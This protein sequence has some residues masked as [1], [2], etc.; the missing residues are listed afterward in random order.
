MATLTNTKIKDT[1]DGLLKTNDNGVLGGTSKE[2]TDGLGNGSGIYIGTNERLGVGT[3]SPSQK[4]SIAGSGGSLSNVASISLWDNNSNSSRRWAIANGA[5]AAGIDQ[6]GAL[7]FSVATGSSTADPITSGSEAMR[8]T[9]A[10]K[11]GIGETNPSQKLDVAGN[12]KL[13]VDGTQNY[14]TFH[15]TTGDINNT[16]YIG[17]RVYAGTERSE[18]ILY[19]GNDGQ[20]DSVGRDRIRLIGANLCFDVYGIAQSYPSDLNGVGTLPTTRAMTIDHTGNVGIGDSTPS[21]K[22]DVNGTIRATGDIIAYSDARVK[23]NVSTIENALDK[24]T[25]LRGVE[26]NKIGDDKQSIGV[27]AQEI[28][29]VLPQVVQED[30]EGMKSVAYG[31][32]VGVLIEAIKE[33]QQQIDELKKRLDGCSK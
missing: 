13:G 6:I 5:S 17:E 10:G 24:V 14:I 12:I 16:T 29:K 30:G 23:E 19:K 33:Q 1:Y 2:I 32:I 11:V 20:N 25:Q 4:I 28:E 21:Y 27:I 15:G 9:S 8:I 22:L 3:N 31:N 7:T 18:L 26:Y